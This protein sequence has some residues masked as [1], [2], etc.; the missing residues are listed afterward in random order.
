MRISPNVPACIGGA[1]DTKPGNAVVLDAL[2]RM[3]E[4]QESG[5]TVPAIAFSAAFLA[6]GAHDQLK[7]WT[8][9]AR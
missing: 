8:T 9:C 3:C 4:F 6:R 7:I 1:K 5:L 2:V